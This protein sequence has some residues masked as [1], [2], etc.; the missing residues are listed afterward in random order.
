MPSLQLASTPAKAIQMGDPI[1]VTIDGT[2]TLAGTIRQYDY[3]NGNILLED[4]TPTAEA[5]YIVK[6]Y[7]YFAKDISTP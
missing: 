5:L 6:N 1:V 3:D 4:E 2:T 7:W